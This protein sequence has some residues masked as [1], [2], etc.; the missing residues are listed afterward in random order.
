[1]KCYAFCP[2]GCSVS[3]NL[4][5]QCEDYVTSIVVGHDLVPRIRGSNFEMLRFEFLEILA[6]IKVPKIK[7]WR[8]TR[9]P[10]KNKDLVV[11]NKRLLYSKNE[12]PMSSYFTELKSF[13]QKRRGTF[14]E[15]VETNLH[16]P[17]R[18]I[19]LVNAIDCSGNKNK[20]LP[21]WESSKSLREID[22]SIEVMK[23]HSIDNL[24]IILN[25]I[26]TDY[27]NASKGIHVEDDDDDSVEP[28]EHNSFDEILSGSDFSADDRWFILCSRPNGSVSLIPT[29]LSIAAFCC[30]A[31]G[32]NTCSL[33]IREV[34]DGEIFHKMTMGGI[35][36]VAGVTFGLYSYGIEYYHGDVDGY[37]LQCSQTIPFDVKNDVYIKMAR[38]F[39][40]LAFVVGF[41]VICFLGLAN[42]CR[43]RRKW[44]RR[45]AVAI[46]FVTFS[47]SM[48]F[49][50]LLSDRCYQDLFPNLSGVDSQPCRLDNGSKMS[51]ASSVMWFLAAVFTTY[52]DRASIVEGQ[53]KMLSMHVTNRINDQ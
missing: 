41:P 34:E 46:F 26:A 13:Q 40:A 3:I 51:V 47:Q 5:L 29:L 20:Y 30:A 39:S 1:L 53:M 49:I 42:C 24:V 44:F 2:P 38:A 15:L 12:I 52:I 6:R 18:I 31:F 8:D 32:N 17:G 21:Y 16:I 4:A 19:H 45:I 11:R 28:V 23:E 27:D 33:F 35:E 10:C 25:K 22:L 43:I 37:V 7:A 9:I 14:S 36:D 48:I 50:F